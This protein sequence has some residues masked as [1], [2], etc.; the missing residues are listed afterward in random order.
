MNK[1]HIYTISDDKQLE[2]CCG[3]GTISIYYLGSKYI[4][5]ICLYI[6]FSLIG[7]LT[8][9]GFQRLQSLTGIDGL[10]VVLVSKLPWKKWEMEAMGDSPVT[11]NV[12]PY[13]KEQNVQLLTQYLILNHSA[14]LKNVEME[15]AEDFFTNF[16]DMI[17]GTFRAVCRT[18][19][20]LIR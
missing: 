16:S 6:Y 14:D 10:T 2:F 1:V 9:P 18:L 5:K 19:P 20:Q 7:D 15:E 11:I 17:L 13:T 8:L 12:P 3:E 4:D